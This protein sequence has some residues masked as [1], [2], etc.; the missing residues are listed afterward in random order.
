MKS[1]IT[2]ALIVVWI[3]TMAFSTMAWADGA[4]PPP[5]V[6]IPQFMEC[7]LIKGE[8]TV[9]YEPF[10]PGQTPTH[11]IIHVVLEGT[12]PY[13]IRR[14]VT[15]KSLDICDYQNESMK[16]LIE[17]YAS[18]P[19]NY[20]VHKDFNLEGVPVISEI[21]LKGYNCN[22]KHKAMLRGELKIRV[23]PPEFFIEDE[24]E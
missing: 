11:F 16:N 23:Y 6:G 10:D 14:T 19:K 20:K 7:P 9:S 13:I 21:K 18:Y 5:I 22:D 8:F 3:V 2:K 24:P 12:M 15:E 1:K 4:G 17:K